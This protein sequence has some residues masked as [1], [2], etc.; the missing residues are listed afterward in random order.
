M[1]TQNLTATSLEQGAQG[2]LLH[3][4]WVTSSSGFDPNYQMG[5]PDR[6]QILHWDTCELSRIQC[7][8]EGLLL[9]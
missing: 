3:C 6:S 9:M 7:F 4:P 5:W 2:V 1:G 8:I